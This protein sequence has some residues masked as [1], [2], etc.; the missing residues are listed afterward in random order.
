MNNQRGILKNVIIFMASFIFVTLL[1]FIILAGIMFFLPAGRSIS[2]YIPI[3]NVVNVEEVNWE[4]IKE[5]N[6]FGII[7]DNEGDVVKS[8]NFEN[9]KNNTL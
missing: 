2:E 9:E 6:G 4:H 8:F 1:S 5:A 7:L 3:S